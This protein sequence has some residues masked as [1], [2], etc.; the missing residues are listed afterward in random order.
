MYTQYR[1]VR[2]TKMSTIVHHVPICQIYCLPNIPCIW[3]ILINVDCSIGVKVYGVYFIKVVFCVCT[4]AFVQILTSQWSE[5]TF[6]DKPHRDERLHRISHLKS[7]HAFWLD[8]WPLWVC[9][10]VVWTK[11]LLYALYSISNLLSNL[12]NSLSIRMKKFPTK[13]CCMVYTR[14]HSG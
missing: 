10:L 1:L 6:K 3:Y 13:L 5:Y 7:L 11:Q 8:E 14:V 12:V 2:Q 9:K 4:I